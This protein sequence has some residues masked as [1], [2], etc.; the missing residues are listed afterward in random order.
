MLKNMFNNDVKKIKNILAKIYKIILKNKIAA[1][2]ITNYFTN[3]QKK[4]ASQTYI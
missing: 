4:I 2:S 3:K 1:R